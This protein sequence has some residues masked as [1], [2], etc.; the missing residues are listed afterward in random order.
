MKSQLGAGVTLPRGGKVFISVKD[1]DKPV[2]TLLAQRLITMGFLL[3]A[4]SG[5][6]RYLA[7]HNLPVETIKKVRE[8]RPHIVDAMK[9]EQIQLVFNTT[10]D[11]K[12]IADSFSLRRTALT[13]QIPYYT[14]VSGARAAVEAIEALTAGQL[15]VAPLQSYFSSS[16]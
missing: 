3:V 11:Q 16:F 12:A 13:S 9:S 6:A 10:E 14:T 1:E 7:E 5:T 4:T 8:G 15:E 2:M